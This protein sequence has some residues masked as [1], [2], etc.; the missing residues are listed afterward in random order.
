[1]MLAMYWMLQMMFE[2]AMIGWCMSNG[3]YVLA[4][5]NAALLIFGAVMLMKVNK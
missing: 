4:G 2:G 5:L 1:M 3:D